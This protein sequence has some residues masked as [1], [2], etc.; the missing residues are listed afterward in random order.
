[1]QAEVTM[2]TNQSFLSRPQGMLVAILTLVAIWGLGPMTPVTVALLVIAG[3]FLFGLRRPVWAVGALIFSQ[4]T[5]TSYMISTPLGFEISLRLLLLIVIGFILWSPIN[6]AQ[7]TLGPKIRSVLIPAFALFALVLLS[8]LVNSDLNVTFREFRNILGG[9]L[10]AIFLPAVTNNRRD[11]KILCG[12]AFI[13]ITASAMMG[14]MQHYEILGMDQATLLTGRLSMDAESQVGVPGM[15]ETQLELAYILTT[16]LLVA[17]GMY[18]TKAVSG[19]IR[20]LLLLSILLMGTAIYLTYTRSAIFALIPGLIALFLLLKTRIRAGMVIVALFLV[21]GV[22]E[23]IDL[24]G[25]IQFGGR[26]ES[27]QEESAMSRPILWQAGIAIALDNPI[28]GIGDDQFLNMSPQYASSVDPELM[29]WENERYWEFRTLGTQEPHNDFLNI[30]VSYG[31]FALVAYVWLFVAV[32]HK[33]L[34][35]YRTSRSRFLKGL[36]VGLAAA[37]VAYGVSAFYH[38]ILDTL[39]LFWI[40]IGFALATSKLASIESRSK[41]RAKA[42]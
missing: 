42:D 18:L 27:T 24:P 13:G 11:L 39:P 21:L 41:L 40:L 7:V 1:M 33:F 20:G 8:N 3:L 6:Q 4:F 5:T 25:S 37:L 29:E 17:V 15:S 2:Q 16:G 31:T 23:M 9:L 30:W 34:Y 10:I 19:G 35:S 36:S 28:L 38:N 22:V 14:M 12:V 32:L 26:S